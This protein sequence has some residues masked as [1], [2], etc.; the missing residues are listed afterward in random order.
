MSHDS[1]GATRV[2]EEGRG[3]ASVGEILVSASAAI[4]GGLGDVSTTPARLVLPADL[5]LRISGDTTTSA[6]AGAIPIA[7][8]IRRDGDEY[9]GLVAGD[10]GPGAA[11]AVVA[12]VGVPQPAAADAVVRSLDAEHALGALATAA[13]VI[14]AA[15][16]A[17]ADLM[18]DYVVRH[19]A[20]ERAKKKGRWADQAAKHEIADVVIKRDIAEAHLAHALEV[21]LESAPGRRYTI[22]ALLAA[23]DGLS[24]AISA[25]RRTAV[26]RAD[27]EFLATAGE[28]LVAAEELAD[29]AGRPVSLRT[30]LFRATKAL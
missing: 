17:V 23:S 9:A 25:G 27:A 24:A 1:N 20:E 7:I 6:P 5:G 10:G 4:L 30:A 22:L 16:I 29:A 18:A 2:L 28:A 3:A 14:A 19:L 13:S 26:Q 11:A 12:G 15:Q 21:G 8:G